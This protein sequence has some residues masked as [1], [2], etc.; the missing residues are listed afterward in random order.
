MKR[1]SLA[2]WILAEEYLVSQS[3]RSSGSSGKYYLPLALHSSLVQS[4]DRSVLSPIVIWP[5][6]IWNITRVIWEH[7]AW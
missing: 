1:A 2:N 6:D 7:R 3:A 5:F 4:L